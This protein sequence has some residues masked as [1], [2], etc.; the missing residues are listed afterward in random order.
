MRPNGLA[1][2]FSKHYPGYVS[3][4]TIMQDRLNVHKFRLEK[5]QDDLEVNDDFVML[6][7]FSNS[8][9]VL[10]DKGYQG[11]AD[12]LRAV[13]PKKKPARG[14]LSR[15]DEEFNKKL[16]SDRIIVE[17]FFGRLGML[18]TVCSAKY[19]WSENMYDTFF[20]ISIAFTNFHITLNN[21]EDEDGV[22]V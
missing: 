18:W 21:L 5:R 1:S 13:I 2:A 12:V 19:A 10:M 20:G 15:D 6:D 11:A 3:D 16:S 17:N 4:I 14:V 9:G 8:W 22:L 7:K